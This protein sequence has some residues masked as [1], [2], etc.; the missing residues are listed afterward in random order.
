MGTL[1]MFIEFINAFLHIYT[2]YV[3]F[4][5][6]GTLVRKKVFVVGCLGIS[7]AI[8]ALSLLWLKGS[9]VIYF[10]MIAVSFSIALLFDNK[11]VNKILYTI[12][13]F[14]I[15]GIVET[16]IGFLLLVLFKV[17]INAITTYS[18]YHIMGMLLSKLVIFLIVLFIRIKKQSTLLQQYK[19]KYLSIFLFPVSTL[20]VVILQYKIFI[21]YPGQDR[22]TKYAVLI[23]YAA[24][25]FANII[26]FDF[27]DSLYKNAVNQSKLQA[28][29]EIILSQTEQYEA[30]ID[31]NMQILK[32]RHDHKN[33]CVGL[34]DELENGN[35]KKAI[36]ILDKEYSVSKKESDL[37]TGTAISII[38]VKQRIANEKGI[39]LICDYGDINRINVLPT[40][41]A[42]M[43]GN[44]L[45]NAIEAC[46]ALK[47]DQYK[48]IEISITIKNDTIYVIIKNPV[49][50]NVDV[51]NLS[52]S[53]SGDFTLHGFGIISMK[54]I[55]KKYSGE[56]LFSCEDEVF[57]TVIMLKNK[58]E[59]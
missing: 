43:L 42:I 34:R 47:D 16:F 24:L 48:Y 59:Q 19:R 4:S 54:Q 12:L 52:T 8:L 44:A 15:G 36:A 37:L 9:M 1:N 45:D 18:S 51:N 46:L 14:A 31:H 25:V 40:D 55:A 57:T 27:I 21:E 50:K 32:I 20:A 13:Y 49:D 11:L 35:V 29:D 41:W 23:S 3:F 39:E 53:K 28:A 58:L 33:F 22:V 56:I 17:E 5:S 30:L 7:T 10:P 38:D 2:C 26:V 6:L